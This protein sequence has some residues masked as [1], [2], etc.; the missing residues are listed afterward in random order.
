[1]SDKITWTLK[2]FAVDQLTDYYK[3]PRSLSKDQYTQLKKSLDKFGMIDK[4]IINL[5][6]AHTVIGGHQRL[7][8][9]RGDNVKAVECWIPDREL[10]G[11]EVEELNIRLNKNTGNWDFDVLANQW[12]VPDLLNWG[13][14][15]FELGIGLI[16]EINNDVSAN[17]TK[18]GQYDKTKM[19]VNIGKILIFMSPEEQDRYS[20]NF[21]VYYEDAVLDN[22]DVQEAVR[23]A[24]GKLADE[25]RDLI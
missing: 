8:V 25:I 21:G 14:D 5:D 12:E 2:T 3:N 11:K 20:Q 19:P 18:A 15:K 9:L 22:P 24:I 17:T 23:R 10:D 13:F 6:A 16:P 4:P 1:M 7:H